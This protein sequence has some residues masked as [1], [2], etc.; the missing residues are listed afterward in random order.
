[1]SWININE[2]GVPVNDDRYQNRFRLSL[3]YT[4]FYGHGVCTKTED[5]IARYNRCDDTFYEEQSEEPIN[6][7]D[8]KAWFCAFD[9]D[10]IRMKIVYQSAFS[11]KGLMNE[12]V[13]C[14]YMFGYYLVD[15]WFHTEETDD[16]SLSRI[17]YIKTKYFSVAEKEYYKKV[18][19]VKKKMEERGNVC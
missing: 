1:M 12:I 14:Y 11:F 17:N 8:I 9:D 18:S 13:V 19:D 16:N 3:D 7:S 15:V 10:E 2:H 6:Y 4:P 5:V